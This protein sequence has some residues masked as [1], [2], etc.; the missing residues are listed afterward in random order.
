MN[1]PLRSVPMGGTCNPALKALCNKA[2][3]LYYTSQGSN[4]AGTAWTVERNRGK[5]GAS[6]FHT[7]YCSFPSPFKLRRTE[8]LAWLLGLTFIGYQH[9]LGSQPLVYFVL[10]VRDFDRFER[11]WSITTYILRSFQDCVEG[12][13]HAVPGTSLCNAGSWRVGCGTDPMTVTGRWHRGT[14]WRVE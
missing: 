3:G 6:V 5:G 14:A 1:V 7:A 2:R 8:T 4:R 12:M 9:A 11:G 10:S 13:P